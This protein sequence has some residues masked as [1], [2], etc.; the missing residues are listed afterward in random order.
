M[1][2]QTNQL[3]VL[4]TVQQTYTKGLGSLFAHPRLLAY[5]F[6]TLLGYYILGFIFF[7][8]FYTSFNL[9]LADI[10]VRLWLGTGFFV[11]GPFLI[12]LQ[13]WIVKGEVPE[14]NFFV[15]FISSTSIKYGLWMMAVMLA[16]LLPGLFTGLVIYSP[17][18][19]SIVRILLILPLIF[20][21]VR[22][23][24]VLTNL[25]VNG[26]CL[27]F[28]ESF[29]YTKGHTLSV[30]ISFLMVLIPLI[31][32]A[33]YGSDIMWFLLK[34]LIVAFIGLDTPINYLFSGNLNPSLYLGAVLVMLPLISLLF[35]F[36]T[37][38]LAAF[39]G[40]VHKH[41]V[42]LGDVAEQQPE[43]VMEE[44]QSTNS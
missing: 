1:L 15:S 8:I 38:L 16:F 23:G 11:A 29:A 30:I 35:W 21:V 14:R 34:P 26:K 22:F 7:N 24:L 10:L 44:Q 27:S 12:A 43:N 40:I 2:G 37:H 32:L 6:F 25:A 28:K 36:L 18:W 31:Y 5:S 3:P 20:L 9:V 41:L 4:Q 33:D 13:K 19:A 17:V 42:S 39:M